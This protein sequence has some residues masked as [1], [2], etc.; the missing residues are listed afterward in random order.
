MVASNSHWVGL[1]QSFR[2]GALISCA[3]GTVTFNSLQDLEKRGTIFVTPGTEIYAGVVIGEC[4]KEH[5]LEVNPC[6]VKATHGAR[7]EFKE[8]NTSIKASRELRLEE[9]LCYMREDH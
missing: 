7:M 8:Q 5:D 4:S 2:K 9:W 1:L 6:R 3:D